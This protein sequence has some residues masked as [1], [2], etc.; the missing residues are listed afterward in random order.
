MNAP[1]AIPTDPDTLAAWRVYELRNARAN[2]EYLYRMHVVEASNKR[3]AAT[4]LRLVKGD[5]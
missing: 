2:G 4:R 3:A 5:A 1:D